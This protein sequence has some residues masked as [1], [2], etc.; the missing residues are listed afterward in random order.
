[1]SQHRQDRV[2]PERDQ[3][4]H[5][6]P[7]TT[8]RK[9]HSVLRGIRKHLGGLQQRDIDE[10]L[11]EL[12]RER[13]ESPYFDGSW[14]SSDE[15]IT[16]DVSDDEYLP[17]MSVGE[18]QPESELEFSGF[19]DY[20]G[21]S[22]EEEE[23]PIVAGRDKT[24]SDG[25]SEGDGP[26]GRVGVRSRAARAS[27]RPRR[28]SQRRGSLGEG[29]S[30]EG[31][32]GWLE[33]PT[34]PNMHPFTATPGLTV[35]VPLTALGFIQLFLTREL[36]E[37]LVAETADYA[38]Y[39]REE[40]QTTL[41][42]RWQ[43]CNL[44][45]MAHFLG[46]HIFFGITPAVDVRQYW[47]R[48]FFLSTPNVPDIMPRDSFLALNRYFNAFN[49]RAIP[50]NNPDRLILVRPVLDYIRERSQFLVVPSQNL[51]L[52]EGMMP[53]KGRLS[54]KVYNPKK[55]KK[56]GVKIFFIT[57]SNTGYV[58]DFSVYSGVFST[59]RDTVF[60]L[61]DRFRNQGYHLFMDNYYNS[62]SLAQEL[63]E[64]GVHVSG[65]IRLVRGAPN[66][67]K[68]FASQ[69]Q[70]LDRGET[71]WRRKGDVFIICW[72]G[73]RL[74]PMITTSYEPIQEEVVQRKKTRRQGRVTYEEF[75]VQR[76]TVIGHYNRHLGGVDLFDQLI[77]YY[78]FARRTRRW[79]QKLL[80][81]LLQLALQN[82]YILY[83][84]YNSDT[85]RLSHF[86]FLEVAGN[87][88]INFNPEEWP[89]NTA[90]LPRAPDLPLEDRADVAR[91][92]NLGRPA[93]ADAAH[94]AATLDDAAPA[95]AAVAAVPVPAVA[96]PHIPMSRRAVDRRRAAH[97]Q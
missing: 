85:Q 37:Y 67:L 74:V 23:A 76:P 55:P 58:V 73:V 63:Y 86:Q 44:M 2:V 51:S 48:N 70:H 31:D 69:P 79:T 54:I 38:R 41:S 45:D 64:A 21:E 50:R 81:Y 72:K 56:Y 40:L 77:Q 53:Y 46:L 32:E 47:R 88:L 30:S 89:S 59:L 15:D 14:S 49:R 4:P 87:A 25:E 39:C 35:P 94:A 33:D 13:V 22:E 65:T 20:E 61:V 34:P 10:Y 28:R 6:V 18:P 82:A 80:K 29:S 8:P 68:R 62:V 83:C 27:A 97:L 5:P 60:G 24:E 43:G 78:P 7:F 17:P 12:D 84:G 90:P 52:N 71:E 16:S 92:A 75:R 9:H 3:G 96:L 1:M 95:D 93:P 91:R 11:L 26:V 36:L 19:S 66:V 57:E 42:Y